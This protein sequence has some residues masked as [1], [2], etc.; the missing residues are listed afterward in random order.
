MLSDEAVALL[1]QHIERDGA[2]GEEKGQG[3]KRDIAQIDSCPPSE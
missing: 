3:R 1:R 2:R